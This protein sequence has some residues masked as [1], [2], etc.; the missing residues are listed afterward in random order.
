MA[1]VRRALA[2]VWW[3]GLRAPLSVGLGGLCVAAALLS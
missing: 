2:P 1:L 3:M